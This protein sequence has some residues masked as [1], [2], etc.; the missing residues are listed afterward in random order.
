MNSTSGL[1][2][3]SSRVRVP[4]SASSR[5]LP[6]AVGSREYR[7]AIVDA[8]ILIPTHD[9]PALVPIA[10]RS[11]LAQRDVSVEVLVVGD[12]VGDDTRAA[13]AAFSGDE[14]VRFFDFPK[15]ERHG[16]RH[17]H[18]A[19]QEARGPVVC[20]LSDD[21]ILLPGHVAEMRRLLAH[22]EFAHSAPALV[23]PDGVLVARPADLAR[24]EFLALIRAGRNNFI[25]LTGA[26][27]TRALYE[28]LPEGW[29]PAPPNLPTDLHMWL[30][31][32]SQPDFA[33]A[34][35]KRLTAIHFP[36][37]AWREVAEAERAQALDTWLARALAPGGD[38]ELEAEFQDATRRV[39]QDLKL[40]SL[41]LRRSLGE[42]NRELEERRAPA[43]KRLG[44]RA[45]RRVDGLR[46][47]S[48]TT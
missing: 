19:L 16:E 5:S 15:G 48:G 32:T 37:P 14:R 46:R 34:T 2:C 8:T 41:S 10:V 25:S 11:A 23:G 22:V 3:R 33:G 1:A 29:H 20:Y 47:D 35:G 17:R 31:V 24:P 44:R 26:A 4:S 30:Q 38:H 21:D 43:W 40:R 42:A 9:H 7:R 13:L 36:D 27:H 39:A 45:R 12:G 18:V 6:G 28:R